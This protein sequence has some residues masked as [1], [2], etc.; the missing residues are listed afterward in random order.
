M[1]EAKQQTIFESLNRDYCDDAYDLHRQS[2]SNPWSKTAFIDCLHKPYFGFQ[3]KVGD[4]AVAYYIGLNVVGEVTLMDIGVDKAYQGQGYGKAMLNQFLAQSL[5]I[6][7][8]EVWLEVR[9][10]NTRAIGLYE[11]FGFELIETRKSY[12]TLSSTSDDKTDV[13]EDALIMKKL[14]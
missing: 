7:G 10:S 11:L 13:K 6:E 4:R 2:H 5:S 14:L 8:E 3:M 12:Y 9:Q 1:S